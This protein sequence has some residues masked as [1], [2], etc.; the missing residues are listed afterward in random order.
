MNVPGH[1]IED[2]ETVKNTVRRLI[3]CGKIDLQE[4]G[5][6]SIT[7]NPM[8]NYGGRAVNALDREEEKI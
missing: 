5:S 8:P 7:N 3:A 2:C 6:P 1:S 4:K